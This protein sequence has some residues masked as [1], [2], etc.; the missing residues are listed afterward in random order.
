MQ[1]FP[2]F[3]DVADTS[4]DAKKK[5]TQRRKDAKEEA[6]AKTPGREDLLGRREVEKYEPRNCLFM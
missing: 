4:Q 5:L 2:V 3:I 1:G 6:H